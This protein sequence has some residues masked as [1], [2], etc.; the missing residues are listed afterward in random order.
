[1]REYHI[2]FNPL[3]PTL[4]PIDPFVISA[5]LKEKALDIAV[6]RFK[7][8]HPDRSANPRDYRQPTVSWTRSQK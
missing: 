7:N 6:K 1:M 4:S 5:E 3:N 8:G 2:T